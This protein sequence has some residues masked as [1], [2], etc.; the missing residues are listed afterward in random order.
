VKPEVGRHPTSLDAPG[1]W[2]RRRWLVTAPLVLV[3][4]LA[5]WLLAFGLTENPDQIRSAMIGRR[6][7]DFALP[8]IDGSGSVRLASLRGQVVVVNFWASWCADCLTEHPALAA[9]W[10]RFRDQGVTML[11]VVYQDTAGDAARFMRELG[12]TWPQIADPGERTAIA[13]GVRGVPE[14]FFIGPDGRIAAQH[15]GAV[16]YGLLSHEISHLLERNR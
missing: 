13:Y 4:S 15:S 16:T 8:T 6:A 12:G 14:T 10:Q 1:S 9:A 2:R 11:G 3:L 5:T 7:P